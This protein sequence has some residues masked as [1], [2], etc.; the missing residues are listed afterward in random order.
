MISPNVKD[1]PRRE[2]ARLVQRRC[3]QNRRPLREHEP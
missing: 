2:L 1:E 3:F